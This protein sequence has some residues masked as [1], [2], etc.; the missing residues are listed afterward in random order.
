MTRQF[1]QM[2]DQDNKEIE[3]LKKTVIEKDEIISFNFF[4]LSKM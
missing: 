4:W 1:K 2:Q 3:K